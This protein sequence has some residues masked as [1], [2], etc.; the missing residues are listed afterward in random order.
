MK[1]RRL[2]YR[3]R[4]CRPMRPRLVLALAL[5]NASCTI[6]SMTGDVL[7]EYAVD[8]LTP[9]MLAMHDVGMVCATGEAMGAFLRSFE[10]VTRPPYRASV[11]AMSSAA[12][13]A[14]E[15]AWS[16]E[17]RSLRAIFARRSIEARDA[18]IA[19][20]RAHAIAADRYFRAYGAMTA[21]FGEPGV[22]CPRFQGR[23]EVL[24]LMGLVAALQ[25]VQHDRASGGQ[26]G[27]P[28]DLPIKVARGADCLDNERWWGVPNALKAT[29]WLTVPG[30]APPDQDPWAVLGAAVDR[31][32]ADGVRLS[33]AIFV[34]AAQTNGDTDR[35]TT[36]IRRFGASSAR[37][38]LGPSGYR[39]FDL[40]AE[41]QILAAS[42]RLWTEALG[43]RTPIG[44]LG[45]FG[46][47]APT[48]AG[49]ETLLDDLE[50]E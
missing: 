22:D 40:L 14:E 50:S 1:R 35:V 12:A 8:H 34:Q 10:R 2:T 47:S 44:A 42:D 7:S 37:S 18:R 31:G 43:Y 30:S 16:E 4:W 33:S 6:T 29:V 28:L 13:C 41:R 48:D 25:A 5:G 46:P 39:L 20:K 19:Q 32:R 3:A 38:A 24:W 11:S 45:T 15:R 23:E 49:D 21:A 36:G 26:I 9:Y 17:L 27:V